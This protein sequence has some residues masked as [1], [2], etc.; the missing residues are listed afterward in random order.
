M[1][2]ALIAA[3]LLALLPRPAVAADFDNGTCQAFLVGDWTNTHELGERSLKNTMYFMADETVM[4]TMESVPPDGKVLPPVRGTW[5]AGRG[6]QF[7]A[8]RVVFRWQ[9]QSEDVTQDIFVI[10]ENTINIPTGGGKELLYKR[11]SAG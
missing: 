5:H 9:T 11:L 6:D 10:D 3:G 8:C 4:T 2:T 7:D 1:R